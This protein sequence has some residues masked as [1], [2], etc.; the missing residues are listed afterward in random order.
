MS[1][2]MW[3]SDNSR[4][5]ALVEYFGEGAINGSAHWLGAVDTN[6]NHKHG[7]GGDALANPNETTLNDMTTLYR[8]AFTGDLLTPERRQHMWARMPNLLQELKDSANYVAWTIYGQALTG[9]PKAF[10]DNLK[11]ATKAGGYT[12]CAN[13]VCNQYHRSIAGYVEIPFKTGYGT[14]LPQ[15]Y[16][17]GIFIHKAT[18]TESDVDEAFQVAIRTLFREEMDKALGTFF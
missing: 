14:I 17:F 3:A 10:R 13:K 18:K 11:V 12:L 2:M 4:T 1:K 16:T 9:P 6:I 8:K 15:R 5:A 7:C